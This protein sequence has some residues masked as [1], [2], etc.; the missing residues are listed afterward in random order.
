MAYCYYRTQKGLDI[1]LGFEET[2]QAALQLCSSRQKYI[3]PFLSS[4]PEAVNFDI[5]RLFPY[6]DITLSDGITWAQWIESMLIQP[7]AFIRARVP[8]ATLTAILAA[9]DIPY[10]HLRDNCIALPNGSAADKVLP[11]DSYVVQDASSQYTGT[12]FQPADGQHWWDCCSGA[13]GKSL[14]LK[15]IN[16]KIQ[17]TVSDKRPTILHN[18]QQRF[19][20]YHHQPPAAFVADLSSPDSLKKELGNKRFD[21]IICDVPCTGSGTWART[22]EQLY[23]FTPSILEGISTLQQQ[24]APNVAQYL[25]PGGT[26]YYIT[27]SVFQQENETVVDKLIAA[28]QSL[29]LQHS[30]LINGTGH[31]AD[32]M[33]IAV[34]KKE[35]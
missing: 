34:L 2:I 23:F 19:K 14:L 5:Q 33:F 10:T 6:D 17:L 26:V 13:G 22:P 25:K 16:R 29:S 21:S 7:D 9:N 15:D 35:K 20:Q 12:Y 11:V 18:L 3:L 32:S 8:V 4:S 31:K 30:E 28:D 1:Q 27:C 24:I